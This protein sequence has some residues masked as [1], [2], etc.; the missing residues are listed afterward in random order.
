MTNQINNTTNKAQIH[1][2][3]EKDL[4]FSS[5]MVLPLSGIEDYEMALSP[6]QLTV[7]RRGRIVWQRQVMSEF[8]G[9]R[10]ENSPVS[11]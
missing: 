9:P 10:R 8:I 2:Q 5:L 3:R 7:V 1:Q 11:S 6:V 4:P